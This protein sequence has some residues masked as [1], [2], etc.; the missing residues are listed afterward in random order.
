MA[1]LLSHF[2]DAASPVRRTVRWPGPAAASQGDSGHGHI[3]LIGRGGSILTGA[4]VLVK[5]AITPWVWAAVEKRGEWPPKTAALRPHL[6]R[7]AGQAWPNKGVD[8][9]APQHARRDH[10]GG[11]I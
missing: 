4:K 7:R 2:P 3:H 11:I 5:R 1:P 10:S 9:H 8:R 6:P